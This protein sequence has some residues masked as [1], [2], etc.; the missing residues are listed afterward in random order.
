MTKNKDILEEI[1]A[2]WEHEVTG[3]P[4]HWEKT[5]ERVAIDEKYRKQI[6]KY[7][8]KRSDVLEAIGELE[9]PGRAWGPGLPSFQRDQLRVEIKKALEKR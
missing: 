8:I 1:L 3:T 6:E 7:Y 2:D 9:E 4:K 5:P